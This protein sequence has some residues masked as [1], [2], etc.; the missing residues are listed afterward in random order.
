MQYRDRLFPQKLVFRILKYQSHTETG[1]PGEILVAPNTFS[2]QQYF[3]GGRF[4]QAVQVLNQGGLSGTGMPD[5]SHKLSA[6]NR[7]I[8]ILNGIT[9]EGRSHSISVRQLFCF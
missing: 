5:D 4:Q 1:L 7:K 3:A 9:L 6:L 8:H 2:V